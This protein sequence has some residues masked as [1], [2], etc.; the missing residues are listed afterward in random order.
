M[1]WVFVV[2]LSLNLGLYFW[3]T[4]YQTD[5]RMARQE[6]DHNVS[7]KNMDLVHEC[8]SKSLVESSYQ[9]M[10]IGPFSTADTFSRASRALI[11]EGFGFSRNVISAREL[12]NFRVFLGPFTTEAA[13]ETAKLRL[14]QQQLDYYEHE[15]KEGTLL[16]VGDL[17]SIGEA[18]G[19][20]V[21]D[22]KQ[23]G[24]DAKAQSEVRTLGPWRWLEVSDVVTEERRIVL[25][26]INW[27]DAKVQVTPVFCS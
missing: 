1:K 21:A 3:V 23:R 6:I 18:A 14:D 19:A 27:R 17:F 11:N 24:F 8:D 4:G 7:S 26:Q 20:Y 9:C 12:R 22:L 5:T 16:S 25:R 13:K 10:R 15:S 2:L